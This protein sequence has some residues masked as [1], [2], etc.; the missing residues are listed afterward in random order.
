MPAVRQTVKSG[1]APENRGM[2]LTV[3]SG[4]WDVAAVQRFLE[5]SVIPVRLASSG[6]HPLVQS[7]WF[8]PAPDGLWCATQADSVLARRLARDAR[9]GFEVAADAPPYRGV[10]G[11]GRARLVPEA[12]VDTLPR[13]IERYLG[14]EPTPLGSWLMSRI[15][16]EVAVHLDD[17]AVTSWD[18][19][20]RMRTTEG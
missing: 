15:E 10:R 8:L 19:T 4:P 6:R 3:R 18:Y 2:P 14:T 17:L 5:Q 20:P 11:T 1:S 13:L 9:I 12:A 16:S 7:L